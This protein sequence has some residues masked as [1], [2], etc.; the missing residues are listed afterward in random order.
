MVAKQYLS[1]V[2]IKRVHL[3]QY[4]AL[5]RRGKFDKDLTGTDR[6]VLQRIELLNTA[7]S[8]PLS[9]I[10]WKCN[11]CGVYHT[12]PTFFDVDRILEGNKGGKY[13][14]GNIQVLC[15][16]CHKCKSFNIPFP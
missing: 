7:S 3:K 11:H 5:G 1:D 4:Y 6:S 12:E 16:N 8:K 9:N 2:A 14:P 10:G 15:P 13:E